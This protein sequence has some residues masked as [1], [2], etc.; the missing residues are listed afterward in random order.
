MKRKNKSKSEKQKLEIDINQEFGEYCE[1]YVLQGSNIDE[2][3]NYL[4]FASIAWNLSLYPQETI[5]EQ[6]KIIS[7]EYERLNP[8][9]LKSEYLQHDL[10][11]LVDKKLDL[12]PDINRTITKV[13]VD[14]TND[15]Y[16]TSVQSQE[17]K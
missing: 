4:H 13:E 6:I 11:L 8:G 9:M 7:D 2:V 16:K 10:K 17:F 12:Y 1:D 15:Q 14:E 5:D 3:R